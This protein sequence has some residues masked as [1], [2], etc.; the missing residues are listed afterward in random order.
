MARYTAVATDLGYASFDL[1]RKALAAADCELVL[2]EDNSPEGLAKTCAPAHGL[3]ARQS[4]I[5]AELIGKMKNCQVIA[6]YGVGVDSVDIAAATAAGIV[7][8]HVPNYCM[9]DVASHALALLL[10]AVRGTVWRDRRVRSGAWDAGAGYEIHRFSGRTLGI[11][12]L[13]AIPQ[14]LAELVSG[15]GMRLL[16]HDPYMAQEVAEK[17]KV[18]LVDL[19]TLC[20]ESDYVSVHAPLNDQ[21]RHMLSDAEF[22]LMKKG[23]IVVNTSRGPVIDEEALARALEAGKVFTAALDVYEAEPLPATS[24]LRKFERVILSDHAG[25][26]SEEAT[27][28]LQRRTAEAVAAVLSGKKPESVVNPEVY[29]KK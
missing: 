24:P 18:K 9:E 7:V 12:G 13:G 14:K 19:A 27:A 2:C 10:S 23:V 4:K 28:E 17:L 16:A 25:W 26:Y 21:T 5:N 6:R 20:R 29:E 11:V 15:F 8:A 3:L 1:E 22:E